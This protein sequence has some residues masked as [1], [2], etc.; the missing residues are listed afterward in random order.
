MPL[1][2]ALTVTRTSRGTETHSRTTGN[3][4]GGNFQCDIS[5]PFTEGMKQ[6]IQQLI[7]SQK[8][9]S[10]RNATK[11]SNTSQTLH[12]QPELWRSYQG[13]YVLVFLPPDCIQLRA[14][15]EQRCQCRVKLIIFDKLGEK[16]ITCL[17]LRGKKVISSYF[18]KYFSYHP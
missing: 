14:S 7:R 9:I 1:S 8:D 16:N 13:R 5:T 2:V 12:H 15:R 3:A 10:G 17:I 11:L 4:P 18:L 6:I